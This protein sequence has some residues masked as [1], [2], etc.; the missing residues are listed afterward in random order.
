MA[1]EASARGERARELGK[2]ARDRINA[3]FNVDNPDTPPRA[4]Q[5]LIAAATL[6]RAMPAPSTPEARNLHRE[7]QALIEQAAVQQTESSASR[8]RQQGDARG[9]RAA[10]GGEPSVHAGEAA[11]RPANPGRTPAKE[12]SST[13]AGRWTATPAT[14]STLGGRARRMRERRQATTLDGVCRCGIWSRHSPVESTVVY[15]SMVDAK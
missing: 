9:D 2:Q 11:G 1:R 8:I 12:H 13:R 14:S 4:S 5:K 10:Q 3:D 15:P 6:L 7:V